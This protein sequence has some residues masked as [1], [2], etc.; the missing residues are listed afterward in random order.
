MHTLTKSQAEDIGAFCS[1]VQ[2]SIAG[3]DFS[4]RSP[5]SDLLSLF[6]LGAL[7]LLLEEG[8]A[9]AEES[10]RLAIAVLVER[11]HWCEPE[12]REHSEQLFEASHPSH[13]LVR[14]L[15]ERGS[16]AFDSWRCAPEY[17]TTF[18]VEELLE[19]LHTPLPGARQSA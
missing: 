13:G 19:S 15:L 1:A 10:R 18:G 2:A 3:L 17:Y 6:T 16:S 8:L 7:G 4:E 5:A 14:I 9:T 11:F 12:A